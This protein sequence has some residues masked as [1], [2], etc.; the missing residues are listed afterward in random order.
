[1]TLNIH[2]NPP[3]RGECTDPGPPPTR[4]MVWVKTWQM[5][6][7]TCSACAWVFRPWGPPLGKSLEEM[8]LNY[9]LQRD[10]EYAAHRCAEH[11]RAQTAQDSS[12][13][14]SRFEERR[15]RSNSGSL[16]TRNEMRRAV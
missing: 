8:M 15:H 12:K 6:A 14:P 5:E 11:P 7:W 1:M 10:K 2:S 13:I 4:Q 9:E 3:Q 16:D